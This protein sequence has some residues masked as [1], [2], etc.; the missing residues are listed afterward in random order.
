[1]DGATTASRRQKN[2]GAE[3][4][5]P[6]CSL[7]IKKSEISLSLQ[8]PPARYANVLYRESAHVC[9]PEQAALYT[10]D[11][12]AAAAAHFLFFAVMTVKVNRTTS[13]TKPD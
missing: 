11:Q 13:R 12:V 6:F 5:I 1:L 2:S 7:S 3:E 8:S 4:V 10:N 9:V